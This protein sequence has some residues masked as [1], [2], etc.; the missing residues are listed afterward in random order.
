MKLEDL[1][2]FYAR[3]AE[4]I[5]DDPEAASVHEVLLTALE[6]GTLRAACPDDAG[7]WQVQAW[8]KQAILIG[9]RRTA[10][11][12]L[13]GEPP[14]FDKEGFPVRRLRLEDGV[15]IVPGGSSVRRG[16]HVAAGVVIITAGSQSGR[17][18]S[19]ASR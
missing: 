1:K 16:A 10:F 15:R 3:D 13:P 17:R 7:G 11:K 9:F 4:V 19:A 5:L 14:F 12:A 8:V 2:D 6:A 18:S